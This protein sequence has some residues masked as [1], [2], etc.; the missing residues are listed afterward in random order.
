MKK[1]SSKGL[2]AFTAIGFMLIGIICNTYN[3]IPNALFHEVILIVLLCAQIAVLST[4]SEDI[5][6]LR[7]YLSNTKFKDCIGNRIAP[8]NGIWV[9]VARIFVFALFTCCILKLQI[10]PSNLQGVY[11]GALAA[12][13]FIVGLHGYAAFVYLFFF[14]RDVSSDIELSTEECPLTTNWYPLLYTITKRLGT[15]FLLFGALYVLEFA[16]LVFSVVPGA[17]LSAADNQILILCMLVVV[18]LLVVAIPYLVLNSL[19]SLDSIV[20]R[21]REKHMLNAQLNICNGY[22]DSQAD[23]IDLLKQKYTALRMGKVV[24]ETLRDITTPRN[25]SVYIIAVSTIAFNICICA[26]LFSTYIF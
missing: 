26:I 19:S 17:T 7:Q 18:I 9:N 20:M 12:L 24:V 2:L 1:I 23:D 11:G 3:T 14:I 10:L 25:L 4:F 8:K 15:A 16:V 6:V 13:T 22:T 21:W 5:K